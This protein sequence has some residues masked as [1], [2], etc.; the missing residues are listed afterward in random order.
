MW[1]VIV[2][3][4]AAL[5]GCSSSADTPETRLAVDSITVTAAAGIE[6][7]ALISGYLLDTCTQIERVDQSRSDSAIA[8]T[9][10]LNQPGSVYCPKLF[11]PFDYSVRLHTA[12]LPP[13]SYTVTANGESATFTINRD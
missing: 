3:V 6:Y 9:V 11:A 2:P 10:I 4:T 5:T 13:G 1:A 12:E 8:L 7:T